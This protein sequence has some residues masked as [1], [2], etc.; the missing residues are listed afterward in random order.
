MLDRQRAFAIVTTNGETPTSEQ[1]SDAYEALEGDEFELDSDFTPDEG[2]H[3]ILNEMADQNAI[4]SYPRIDMTGKYARYERVKPLVS[5][6]EVWYCWRELKTVEGDTAPRLLI[7]RSDPYLHENSFDFLY[8]TATKAM[9]GL[10]E[11]EVDPEESEE[12]VLCKMTL[13]PIARP[14]K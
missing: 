13:E 2:T 1:L 12:W 6:T 14:K 3:F 9:K 11:M 4:E 10:K 8:K 7:P 5:Q